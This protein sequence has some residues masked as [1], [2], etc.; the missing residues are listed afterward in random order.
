MQAPEHLRSTRAQPSV[1][2]YLRISSGT[3][4]TRSD[5]LNTQALAI[6]LALQKVVEYAMALASGLEFEQRCV[7]HNLPAAQYPVRP[8]PRTEQ[9]LMHSLMLK[10]AGRGRQ[11]STGLRSLPLLSI[12][13]ASALFRRVSRAIA[14]AVSRDFY[15]AHE[16]AEEHLE[17]RPRRRASLLRTST[18]QTNSRF[19]KLPSTDHSF[20]RHQVPTD[21][22]VRLR[23]SPPAL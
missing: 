13:A 22:H 7:L 10:Y 20:H 17:W 16:A 6:R 15:P 19:E 11:A 4:I 14:N 18:V 23:A 3:L 5:L 2:S 21:I 9:A 1:C 12:V 8:S